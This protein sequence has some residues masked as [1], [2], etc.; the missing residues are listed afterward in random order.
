MSTYNYVSVMPRCML[1]GTP[2]FLMWMRIGAAGCNPTGIYLSLGGLIASTHAWRNP[3]DCALLAIS[4]VHSP[5]SRGVKGTAGTALS[6][7]GDVVIDKQ[8]HG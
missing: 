7:L 4:F 5:R 8:V 2:C 1:M 3:T 6:N